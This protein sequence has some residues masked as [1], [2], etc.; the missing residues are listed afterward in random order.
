MR[1]SIISI[2]PLL[3]SFNVRNTGYE[4][5]LDKVKMFYEDNTFYM[6]FL[7]C[8]ENGRLEYYRVF[9]DNDII[10]DRDTNDKSIYL[11]LNDYNDN[12]SHSIFYIE[13]LDDG[14]FNKITF[15]FTIP[16]GD[17]YLDNYFYS[18]SSNIDTYGHSNIYLDK[19]QYVAFNSLAYE[20]K[21]DEHRYLDLDKYGNVS[22]NNNYSLGEVYLSIKNDNIFSYFDDE[23]LI[24]NL[25]IY[26]DSL[27]INENLSLNKYSREIYLDAYGNLDKIYF[28]K[29]MN[30]EIVETIF[31][32]KNF[33]GT[34]IN[35]YFPAYFNLDKSLLNDYEII[36]EDKDFF[37]YDYEFQI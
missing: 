3:L 8:R 22:F 16:Q 23:Y 9:I 15:Y 17:I 5:S 26:N 1:R 34:N 18:L 37:E 20:N 4:F 35:L 2:L 25:D 27:V 21:I 12:S 29:E 13:Y 14:S 24:L 6:Y 28:P 7:P 31:S 11:N 36:I 30:R 19:G 10:V 32:I 33:Y